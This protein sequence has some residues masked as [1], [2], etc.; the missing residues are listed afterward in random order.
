MNL[1]FIKAFLEAI[2]RRL[3]KWCSKETS[4]QECLQ[5]D[6][7]TAICLVI[8]ASA[9]ADLPKKEETETIDKEVDK[10]GIVQLIDAASYF[11]CTKQE[12]A[13]DIGIDKSQEALPDSQLKFYIRIDIPDG[14]EIIDEKTKYAIKRDLPPDVQGK[15]KELGRLTSIDSISS[16][17]R[18]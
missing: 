7:H 14:R 12:D 9:V 1:N 11:L 6:V 16:F 8:P 4:P 15:I 13:S 18:I 5:E 2:V 10:D 17:N 3:K